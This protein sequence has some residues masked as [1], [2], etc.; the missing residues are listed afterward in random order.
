M[1]HKIELRMDLSTNYGKN[2]H[3]QM[4]NYCYR[5]GLKILNWGDGGD[6]SIGVI[7][8]GFLSPQTT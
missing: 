5:L 3:K 7:S 6:I 4:K 1:A 2:N 8:N